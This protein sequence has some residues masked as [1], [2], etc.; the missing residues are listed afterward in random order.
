M[1]KSEKFAL[2]QPRQ[3]LD[4]KA[5]IAELV[6]KRKHYRTSKSIVAECNKEIKQLRKE[7]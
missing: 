2:V 4:K 1:V 3:R 5:M 7:K 6:K